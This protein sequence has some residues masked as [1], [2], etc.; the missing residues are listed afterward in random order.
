MPARN[1][2]SRRSASDSYWDQSSNQSAFAPDDDNWGDLGEG[3][4]A[5]ST[6]SASYD[7]SRSVETRRSRAS[8]GGKG[9]EKKKLSSKEISKRVLIV[10]LALLVVMAGL[11]IWYV[12][13]MGK[14]MQNIDKS[15]VQA[16]DP[17]ANDNE[18]FYALIIGTDSRD[19]KSRG[20][21]DTLILTRV[22]PKE[23]TAHLISIP[24]DTKVQF[25]GK[26]IKINAAYAY[27]GAEGAIQAVKDLSGVPINHVV[28][29]N[30]EGVKTIVDR[31]GGVTVKVP[32]KTSYGGISVPEGVQKLNGEQALTFARVRKT[33][34][35]GDYQ[36]TDNQ[37]QLVK[38][39]TKEILSTSVDKIP[40]VVE[41]VTKAVSTD[42]PLTK[43]VGLS[44]KMRGMDIDTM[45]NAV[46]PSAPKNINGVSYVVVKEAEW[47]AMMERVKAGL[48]PAEEKEKE[49]G[50]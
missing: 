38:A 45:Y 43:L 2:Y 48:P 15:A 5:R 27:K 33:Y 10:I 28:A 44:L 1:N 4:Y 39:V 8:R 46:L 3:S 22:D 9:P 21:S 20:R 25:E 6:T 11:F 26:T 36:R 31:L 12:L 40:G 16:L 24:R 14:N 19:M 17:V 42:M 47:A 18:P 32:P 37:R 30:F 50:K 35:T 13:Q 49:A 41:S 29:V 34:A 23:K 7:P